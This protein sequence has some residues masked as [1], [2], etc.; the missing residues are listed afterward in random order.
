MT[1]PWTKWL[2][3]QT[4]YMYGTMT[5]E[6]TTYTHSIT[7]GHQFINMPSSSRR[8]QTTNNVPN[9]HTQRKK[10]LSGIQTY[11]SH[12]SFLCAGG[13]SRPKSSLGISIFGACSTFF[14]WPPPA[15]FGE[16][17]DSGGGPYRTSL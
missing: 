14:C 5:S 16:A 13:L 6:G 2:A 3:G 8:N 15:F 7:P 11:P 12:S 9:N 17:R 4:R 10:K 1:Q